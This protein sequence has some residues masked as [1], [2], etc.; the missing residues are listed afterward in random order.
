MLHRNTLLA[1]ALALP[2]PLAAQDGDCLGYDLSDPEQRVPMDGETTEWT[3]YNLGPGT[4][5][6]H[7]DT[8]DSHPGPRP[9]S[10]PAPSRFTGEAGRA[11]ALGLAKPGLAIVYICPED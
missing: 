11:Y 6:I 10:D 3:L 9:S 4:V 1:A 5:T 8:G 7:A 2:T